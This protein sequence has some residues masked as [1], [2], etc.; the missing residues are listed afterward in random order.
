M[1]FKS[2]STHTRN[3]FFRGV[4][5]TMKKLS[6]PEAAYIAGI[7]DGEG[8]VSIIN[9]KRSKKKVKSGY[10]LSMRITIVNS[11]KVLIDWLQKHIGGSI[12]QRKKYSTEH[13][14]MYQL[15]ITLK[16]IRWLV[17]QIQEFSVG[18]G[19]QLRIIT[20]V[21][22]LIQIG[23]PQRYLEVKNLQGELRKLHSNK[24]QARALVEIKL[25]Q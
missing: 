18:K 21:F 8:S 20:H 5:V 4:T 6:K 12:H 17:P 7:I 22:G 24:G 9:Q 2:S 14:Q 16:L 19:E 3:P 10:S 13:S 11:N 15:T 23:K 1:E 25:L